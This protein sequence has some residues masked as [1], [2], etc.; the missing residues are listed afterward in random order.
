[1]PSLAT[2][3]GTRAALPITGLCSKVLGAASI[4]WVCDYHRPLEGTSHQIANILIDVDDDRAKSETY[5]TVASLYTQGGQRL[6][7]TG[8]GRYLDAW[9]KRNGRWAIDPRQFLLDF[10]VTQE[11]PNVMMGWGSRDPHDLSY[12]YLGAL[13]AA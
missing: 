2:Q 9:S 12:S 7:T 10:A 11:A 8:R 4:D 6:L 1:M 3:S 5:V 13:G